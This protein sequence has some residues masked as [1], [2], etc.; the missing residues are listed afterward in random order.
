M[1]KTIIICGYGP[2]I[3]DAM[4][5]K[6]GAEGFSAALVGRNAERV[7]A[8]AK[9]LGAAGLTAAGFACDLGDLS[10]VKRLVADVRAAL[11]PI[12]VLHW[13]AYGAGAG[14]LT[15]CDPGELRG[16]FDVAVHG[17]V[18][19]TQAALPD[20]REHKGAILVTGGGLSMYDANVDAMAVGWHAMG[21]AVAKAAQHKLVGVLHTKLAGDGIYV[22]EVT[23]LGA[24]K[25]TAFDQGQATLEASGV[26]NEFWRL[27]QGRAERSV[28]YSG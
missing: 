12:H 18:T 10:A 17:L 1:A 8:G 2:G 23:V 4:A 27:Y 3:S 20:L 16:Q 9:A 13:N 11:G 6:F 7:Q 21:L 22:G 19:A 26:A 24:V 25:G 28:G 14:D 5:R 15:A